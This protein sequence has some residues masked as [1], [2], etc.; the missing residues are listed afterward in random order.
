MFRHAKETLTRVQPT[1]L[2]DFAGVAAIGVILYVGL[3]LPAIL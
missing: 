2:A 1:I 3:S